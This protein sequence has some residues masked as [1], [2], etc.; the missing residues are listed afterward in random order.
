MNGRGGERH[1]PRALGWAAVGLSVLLQGAVPARAQE[2]RFDPQ[3][4]F[5]LFRTTNIDFVGDGPSDSGFRLGVVLPVN[6]PLENG[7]LSF[8]YRTFFESFE[9]STALNN[10]DHWLSLAISKSPSRNSN[11]GMK[12]G[13]ILTQQQ[14]R[15]DSVEEG[16]LFLNERTKRQTVNLGLSYSSALGARWQWALAAGFWDWS[17]DEIEGFDDETPDRRL[18]DRTELRGS[19]ELTRALSRSNAIGFSLTYRQ[20]DLELSGE[21]DTQS[22]SLVYRRE[23]EER[24]SLSVS[25]GGFVSSGTAAGGPGGSQSDSRS[26]FQGTVSLSR[27]LE[28]LNFTFVVGHTPS[29][30]NDR[31]GTSTN[32]TIGVSLSGNPT[33]KLSWGVFS[34]YASREPNNRLEPT[35][36][37]FALGSSM[38]IRFRREL[39]IRIGINYTNQIA[40]DARDEGSFVA[41]QVG[42][43]WHPLARTRW[44]GGSG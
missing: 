39:S 20:F 5:S 6:R 8:S 28:H 33:R 27:A 10:L 30:G 4:S 1:L 36:D 34:R 35:I 18:E 22:A 29:A 21:E 3:I 37:S 44:A 38:G 43:V 15:A 14:G 7:S 19:F 16:D 11:I 9:Q 42:L 23:I 17:Y 40:D 12:V 31:L 32:T 26:G 2:T 13:Y 41:G 24:M 25:A